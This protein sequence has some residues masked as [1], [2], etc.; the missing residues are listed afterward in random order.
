MM[1]ENRRNLQNEILLKGDIILG[2]EILSD[3]ITE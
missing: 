2:F 1:L 3:S